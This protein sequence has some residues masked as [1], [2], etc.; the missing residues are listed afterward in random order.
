MCM[1][2]TSTYYVYQFYIHDVYNWFANRGF[3][4]LPCLPRVMNE[5]RRCLMRWLSCRE[6]DVLSSATRVFPWNDAQLERTWGFVV[7][8][9]KMFKATLNDNFKN[10]ID[11]IKMQINVLKK[12]AITSIGS[13]VVSVHHGQRVNS[14]DSSVMAPIGD[15]ILQQC[16]TVSC[17]R[18]KTRGF[19]SKPWLL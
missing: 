17:G 7:R 16:R 3:S 13:T 8:Q 12:D 1:I 19:R 18:F 2:F 5:L 15:H 10:N 4:Q 11:V 9:S 14:S 6:P